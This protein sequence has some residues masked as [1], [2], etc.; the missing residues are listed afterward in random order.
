MAMVEWLHTMDQGVLADI[1]GNVL[2]DA[3]PLMGVRSRAE[4][5]KV[6]WAMARAY[7]VE[8]KVPSR[9]DNL[10]EEMIKVP[11]KAPTQRGKAAQVRYLLP[12]AARLAESFADMDQ[13]WQTVAVLTESAVL[14]TLC[15]QERPYPKHEAADL[16][17]KVA[18]LYTS[19]RVKPNLHLMQELIEYQRLEAR[20]PCEYW[21]YKDESWGAWLAKVAM[22][23]GGKQ[24]ASSLALSV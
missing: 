8:A 4:Q 17:R 24:I 7:Y 1:I 22:R 15:S 12:F 9:L 14:L 20:A 10:T 3:L 13:H 19:W 11:G 5:V 6:L 23:R 16:P 18:L 2:W 21:T